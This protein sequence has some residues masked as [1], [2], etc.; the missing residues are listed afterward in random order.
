MDGPPGRAA[1]IGGIPVALRAPSI[2]PIP[3]SPQYTIFVLVK[4][5]DAQKS[6]EYCDTKRFLAGQMS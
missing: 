1:G 6:K 5:G 2:P 4:G 3:E